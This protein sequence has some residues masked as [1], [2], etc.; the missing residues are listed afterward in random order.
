NECQ[1]IADNQSPIRMNLLSVLILKFH[2]ERRR[3]SIICHM[4]LR[5][6]H[7]GGGMGMT[8]LIQVL[9]ANWISLSVAASPATLIAGFITT[10]HIAFSAMP[11]VLANA[12][13]AHATLFSWFGVPGSSFL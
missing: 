6:I 12:I 7:A 11:L 3:F 9:T 2:L 13:S 5:L 1:L 4:I 10:S 8:A